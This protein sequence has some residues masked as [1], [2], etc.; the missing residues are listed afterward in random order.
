MTLDDREFS[1][2][3]TLARLDADEA[4]R[5][6]LTQDVRRI[7]EF[8]ERLRAADVD[9]IEPMT[10]GDVREGADRLDEARPGRFEP[11]PLSDAPQTRDDHVVVPRVVRRE[12][13]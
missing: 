9:G 13:A 4:E 8:V 6:R 11:P 10:H 7:L 12:E 2:L 5:S 1:H 3:L